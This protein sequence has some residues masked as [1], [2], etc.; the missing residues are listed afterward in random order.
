MKQTSEK[1]FTNM[2][3]I[4]HGRPRREIPQNA[5]LSGGAHRGGK[6]CAD[7]GLFRPR[8]GLKRCKKRVDIILL[9]WCNSIT[10]KSG[11]AKRFPRMRSGMD[12]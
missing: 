10:N 8:T 11:K 1:W 9:P 4:Q 6:A 2:N 7:A 3:N 12:A 5:G